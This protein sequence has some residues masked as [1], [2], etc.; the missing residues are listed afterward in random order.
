MVSKMSRKISPEA[1]GFSSPTEASVT[2]ESENDVVGTGLKNEIGEYNCFL[3]VI[4]QSLWNLRRFREEFM[5]T[6]SSLHVHVGDPCVVCALFDV[7]TS[8]SAASADTRREAISPTC[9]RL[10]LSNLYPRSNFF[11]EAQM[12]DASEVLAVIFDCLHK[13]YTYG[14]G[15]SDVTSEENYRITR[16]SDHVRPLSV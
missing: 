14:S 7:F 5:R 4:I 16:G 6:S 10:A 12:N 2:F 9:L 11:Q 8:L 3:N 1:D 13:S 15:A